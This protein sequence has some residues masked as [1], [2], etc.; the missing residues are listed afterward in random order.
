M[1]ELCVNPCVARLGVWGALAGERREG[2]EG[3]TPRGGTDAFPPRY[4]AW[5]SGVTSLIMRQEMGI[6]SVPD[7]CE[8]FQFDGAWGQGIRGLSSLWP[9]VRSAGGPAL[10]TDLK[11]G[12]VWGSELVTCGVCNN[13]T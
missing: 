10:V 6:W 5:L 3:G 1:S 7:F 4:S 11:M 8:L 12:Q 2:G 9:I 13:C